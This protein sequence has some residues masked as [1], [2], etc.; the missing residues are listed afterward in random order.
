MKS[1]DIQTRWHE[2]IAQLERADGSPEELFDAVDEMYMELHEQLFPEGHPFERPEE[3]DA[4]DPRLTLLFDVLGALAVL[5]PDDGAFPW[6]RGG[7]LGLFGHHLAAAED[8]LMAALLFARDAE[9]GTGVAGDEAD[10]ARS[11][12]YHAAK[13]LAL[14]GHLTSA[15]ALVPQLF[16]ED[17]A[18]VEALV[19]AKASETI[20]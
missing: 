18:E 8:Y 7:L 1:Q 10:T 16:P 2:V 17:R 5:E 19:E 14:A 6:E 12:L 9:T 3:V 4:D 15:A 11:A 13:N 20:L